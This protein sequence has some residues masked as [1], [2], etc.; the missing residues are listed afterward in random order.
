MRSAAESAR[1]SRCNSV[2]RA[3]ACAV[4]RGKP[5]RM[6]PSLDSSPWSSASIIEMITS[7]GTR[8]PASM[9]RLAST[10]S[11]V[12]CLT[13]SRSMSPVAM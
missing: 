11:G 8:S 5:S 6:N 2:A 13:F 3:S 9:K 12:P 1:P 10:P 4:V 7:S